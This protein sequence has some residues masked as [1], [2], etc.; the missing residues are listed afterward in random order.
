MSLRIGAKLRLM[1]N[2]ASVSP[3]SKNRDVFSEH[4]LDEDGGRL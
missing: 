2:L 4:S 1:S 3:I